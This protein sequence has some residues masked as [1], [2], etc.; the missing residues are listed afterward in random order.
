MTPIKRTLC[1]G[2]PGLFDTRDV[3]FIAA[4]RRVKAIRGRVNFISIHPS[5]PINGLI[6]ESSSATGGLLSP[7]AVRRVRRRDVTGAVWRRRLISGHISTPA[8]TAA[9]RRLTEEG[10]GAPPLT[11]VIS[12]N[13]SIPVHKINKQ[14]PARKSNRKLLLGGLGAADPTDV[15]TTR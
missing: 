5:P 8:P 15:I 3:S 2:A 7:A 14:P 1:S 10:R 9:R 12:S 13:G 6:L 4:S 11:E